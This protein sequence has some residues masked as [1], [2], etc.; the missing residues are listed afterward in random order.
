MKALI[1]SI[2]LVFIGSL[3]MANPKDIGTDKDYKKEI[4]KEYSIDADGTVKLNNRYGD[5]NIR[6]HSKNQ[7]IINVTI[8]TD[9]P[10]ESRAE[11]VFDR[12]NV[13]FSNS[14]DYVSAKTEIGDHG[15]SWWKSMWKGNNNIEFDIHYEVY[16]PNQVKL[17]IENRYGN[18]YLPNM[19]ND[20]DLELK[21]G[22]AQIG[23]LSG[24]LEFDISY[25]NA[26]I[27]SV[28]DISIDIGYGDVD[29]NS[30]KQIQM[31]SKYSDIRI[32]EAEYLDLESKY[33]DFRIGTIGTIKNEGKY[34]EFDIKRVDVFEIDT[35]YTDIEIRDLG[36]S[37]Q[38]YT[39]YGS[40]DIDNALPSLESFD[41]QGRYTNISLTIPSGFEIEF[42]GDYVKPRFSDSINYTEKD[43]DDN[44]VYI[45]GSHGSNPK[46]QLNFTMDYG[47]LKIDNR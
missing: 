8:T 40:I 32:E 14:S 16:V 27:N 11:E 44:S 36:K 28:E 29:I 26:S 20:V 22:D 12:I 41:V 38:F 37:G 42:E 3:A 24:D 6:T 4:N 35:K 45:K 7:V 33:D 30:A 2:C 46:A 10:N 47:S 43:D 17:D 15:S 25:G 18:V 39:G 23:N 19:M 9:A 21:Y 13:D 34:D 31:E 1:F 5:I